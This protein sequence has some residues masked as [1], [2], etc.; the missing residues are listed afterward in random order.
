MSGIQYPR[1][2]LNLPQVFLRNV[3]YLLQKMPKTSL[4]NTV[5]YAGET[6]L[7]NQEDASWGEATQRTTHNAQLQTYC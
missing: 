5:S 7:T 3:G 6:V 2:E 4:A 1:E